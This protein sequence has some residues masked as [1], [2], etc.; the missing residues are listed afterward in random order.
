MSSLG[1][2]R[3]HIYRHSLKWGPGIPD[4]GLR[5]PGSGIRNRETQNQRTQDPK[6]QNQVLGPRNRN[7]QFETWDPKLKTQNTRTQDSGLM[8][9]YKFSIFIFKLL[10][11]KIISSSEVYCS[12]CS[13]FL[14][15]LRTSYFY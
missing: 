5:N 3:A 2:A 6:I 1:S 13:V 15:I 10:N 12:K 14:I 4:R 8:C 7:P 11:A 9:L